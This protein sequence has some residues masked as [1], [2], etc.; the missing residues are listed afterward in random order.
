MAFADGALDETEMRRVAAILSADPSERA[1]LSPYE[2]TRDALADMFS[3]A[4]TSP[5]PDRLID[6]VLTSPVGTNATTSRPQH[7]SFFGRMREL[8]L[9]E[10]P[11]FASAAA[12]A[13]V[14]LVIAGAGWLTGHASLP[15]TSPQSVLTADGD[16]MFATGVLA[17]ALDTTPSRT[18]LVR[19]GVSVMPVLSF[20]NEADAVCRQYTLSRA[21]GGHF[22]GFGCRAPDGRW[23]ISFHAAAPPS[24]DT[25]AVNSG[26]TNSV[27]TEH[28]NQN[29][30]TPAG[31]PEFAALEGAIDRSIKGDVL[32]AGDEAHLISNGWNNTK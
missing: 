13:C 29:E 11:S 15:A 10:V 20:H 14:V 1:R 19:D 30:Y 22:A 18:T 8:L 25:V 31:V 6:T 4:L 32:S 3:E 24:G 5:V 12:L 27:A 28:T 16:A 23:G 17:A 9:P 21:D 26:D 2:I 7:Q